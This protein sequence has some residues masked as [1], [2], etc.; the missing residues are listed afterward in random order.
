M[1]LYEKTRQYLEECLGVSEE[2][3][4]VALYFNGTSVDTLNELL[5]YYTGY[6]NLE[7]IEEMGL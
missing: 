3:I 2:T 5:Y 4:T 1:S 7:Q 6:R